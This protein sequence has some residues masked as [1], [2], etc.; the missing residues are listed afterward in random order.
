MSTAIKTANGKA[1][2]RTDTRHTYYLT[3][4]RSRM[5]GLK[6]RYNIDIVLEDY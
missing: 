1:D 5:Q 2:I 6:D 4:T 3:G